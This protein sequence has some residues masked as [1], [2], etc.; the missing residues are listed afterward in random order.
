MCLLFL[1][2]WPRALCGDASCSY[3]AA[4]SRRVANANLG[5]TPMLCL[6]CSVP[7]RCRFPFFQ[8]A[9]D[10]IVFWR[11]Q[12][13][14]VEDRL[15]LPCA[16]GCPSCLSLRYLCYCSYPLV[17]GLVQEVEEFFGEGDVAW[18]DSTQCVALLLCA[19]YL[20]ALTVALW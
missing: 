20:H 11:L 1:L 14:V 2:I 17:R 12:E 19:G 3:A 7:I 9:G 15:N 16:L 6:C 5:D 13:D 10:V 18:V 4:F 8:L